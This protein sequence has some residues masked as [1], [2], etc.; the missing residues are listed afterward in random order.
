MT[1][2][3]KSF[4]LAAIGFEFCLF[5]DSSLREIRN[6]FV[7]LQSPNP[8][9]MICFPQMTI[10]ET[11]PQPELHSADQPSCSLVDLSLTDVSKCGY[12]IYPDQ[13]IAR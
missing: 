9:Y 1:Q 13:R 10:A 3:S 5:S 7:P 2:Q 12:R 6:L 11:S 4:H 8:F